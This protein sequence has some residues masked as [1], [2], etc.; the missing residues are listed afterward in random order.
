M[1]TRSDLAGEPYNAQTLV[2]A[3]ARA[4]KSTNRLSTR[5]ESRNGQ[6]CFVESLATIAIKEE[7]LNTELSD[8]KQSIRECNRCDSSPPCTRRLRQFASTTFADIHICN[9]IARIHKSSMT[10]TTALRTPFKPRISTVTVTR[11][12]QQQ[13]IVD[14][15]K[16]SRCCIDCERDTQW[17]NQDDRRTF[18]VENSTCCCCCCRPAIL[19][20]QR[21]QQLGREIFPIN[22]NGPLTDFATSPKSLPSPSSSSA[23]SA[24]QVDFC[25]IWHSRS[26]AP[27]MD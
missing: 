20:T 22:I 16:R 11:D 5:G 6:Q 3:S 21:S 24:R 4:P 2:A 12:K 7:L 18:M 19:T 1:P 25:M 9:N 17:T 14:E 23:N 10:A 26:T 15:E 27:S 8:D 13:R